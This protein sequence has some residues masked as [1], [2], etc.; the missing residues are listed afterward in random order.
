MINEDNNDDLKKKVAELEQQIKIIQES[1]QSKI[2]WKH[3][4]VTIIISI[5]LS[6]IF[7][8]ILV[9]FQQ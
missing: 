9:N 2:S 8:M 4:I 6:N 3:V 7:F 1:S 5:A